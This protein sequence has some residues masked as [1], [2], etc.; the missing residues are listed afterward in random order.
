MSKSYYVKE[1]LLSFGAKFDVFNEYGN[2]EFLVEADKFDI[3]K[4]I[5]IYN[6]NK[7]T[8]LLYMKQ[9][10]RIGAHKYIVYDEN[11]NEFAT[12]QKEFM[13]PKYNITGDIGAIEMESNSF[14]G[15]HYSITKNGN[16]IGEIHKEFTLG[17]D[18]YSLEVIDEE[19]SILLVGLLVMVDMIRFHSDN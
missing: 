1:R 8:K 2:E 5:N 6:Y 12:I 4:N 19:Y 9:Q 3:G 7:S 18:R 11:S 15:R 13:V 14:L 16:V 10:L 17:R